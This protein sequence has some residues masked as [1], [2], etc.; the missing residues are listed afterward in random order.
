MMNF[1]TPLELLDHLEA[2]GYKL[3]IKGGHLVGPP[4]LDPEIVAWV[5]YHKE[6]LITLI[7][8]QCPRCHQPIR[9]AMNTANVLYIEC[10]T[11]P[12]HFA[13][14]MPKIRGGYTFVTTQGLKPS[15]CKECSGPNDGQWLYCS[16]CWL[17]L[18]ED[19]MQ[20][21]ATR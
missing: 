21:Q 4:G 18:I 8:F 15:H 3:K 11:D 14:V 13:H 7:T 2:S 16:G 5:K 12:T 9:E 19:D 17:R 6:S 1:F 10:V 20:A